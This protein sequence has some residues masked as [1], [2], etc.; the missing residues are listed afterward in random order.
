MKKTKHS[1]FQTKIFKVLIFIGIFPLLVISVISLMNVINTRAKN[2]SELQLQTIKTISEKIEKYLEQKISTFNLVIDINPSNI[3][4]VNKESLNFIIKGLKEEAGDINEISFIGRY[5]EEVVKRS[6]VQ[7]RDQLDLKNVSEQDDFKTA[8]SGKNYLGPVNFTLAGPMMRVASQIE[9]KNRE[10]IGVISAEL[11]LNPIDKNIFSGTKLGNEGFVYLVDR[12]GNLIVSSNKDFAK[13]GENLRHID[14]VKDVLSGNIHYGLSSKDK[15]KNSLDQRVIFS[16]MPKGV[17]GWAIISEWP[18]KDAHSVVSSMIV[19]F[20]LI[21]LISLIL[22]V[23]FSLFTARTVVKPVE[24]LKKG[25]DEIGRGNFDYKIQIKTGDEIEE[26]GDDFNKMAGDL[27]EIQRLKEIEIKS[28]ALAESLKK[29]KKLS[30]AKDAF[31][32]TISHQLQTPISVIKWAL[33]SLKRK[34]I[35]NKEAK[36]PLDNAYKGSKDLAVLVSDFITASE[37][38][39]KAFNIKEFK[40]IDVA[41]IVEDLVD[42]FKPKIEKKQIKFQFKK[43]LE[44]LKALGSLGAIR[45][46][47]QNLIDNAICYTK[48]RGEISISLRKV[49]NGL[50]FKIKDTGIGIPESEQSLV[51][52]QFFRASNAV[53]QKNVG[54]GLGLYIVKKIIDGHKGKIWF[55]SEQ[56]KGTTFYFA[57]S[58]KE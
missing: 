14:L 8:I 34:K 21:I 11:D 44:S 56:G 54:T 18:Q 25:A 28:K 50:E 35:L 42:N 22:V 17:A 3:S 27:K 32:K 43:P 58:L 57:L 19:Q 36:E 40:P 13:P 47:I 9:N 51:F 23:I 53:E 10:I 4:E 24:L 48:D 37:L 20:L 26:L 55:E 1:K 7:G 46:A 31:M 49:D 41:G 2:I 38:S 6:E 39:A 30:K 15:Y 5:G 29:E 12:R 33:D 52:S 16:G 45:K